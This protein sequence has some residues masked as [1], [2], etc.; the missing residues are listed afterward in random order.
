MEENKRI[1]IVDDDLDTRIIVK[2]ILAGSGYV[3]EESANG[4]IALEWLQTNT[5]AL[6][7]LDVMMPEMS[8]Y[9]VMIHLKQ[10]PETQNIPVIMLTAKGDSDDL[11]KAYKEYAVDYYI[12]KPFTPRQL[13]AGVKLVLQSEEES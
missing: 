6:I 13:I 11:F 4:K 5:P 12:P 3:V 9:D 10:R 7:I 1:L 8:G 2:T